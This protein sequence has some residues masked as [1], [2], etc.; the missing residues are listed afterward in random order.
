MV[1]KDFKIQGSKENNIIIGD[2]PKPTIADSKIDT[3]KDTELIKKIFNNVRYK[4]LIFHK[5]SFK[6]IY[7]LTYFSKIYFISHKGPPLLGVFINEIFSIFPQAIFK[8][9][10]YSSE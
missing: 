3:N 4:I 2:V 7:D 8:H 1:K 10:S 9:F 5:I 6:I